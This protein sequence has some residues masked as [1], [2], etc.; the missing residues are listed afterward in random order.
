MESK[1]EK[2]LQKTYQLF[3]DSFMDMDFLLEKI[4]SFIDPNIMGYGTTVDEFITNIKDYLRLIHRQREQSKDFEMTWDRKPIFRRLSPAEDAALIIEEFTVKMKLEG[5]THSI[6]LRVSAL[7]HYHDNG[8]K[9]VHWHGSQPVQSENDT[10]HLDEWRQKNE[11]LQKLV[12]QQTADLSVKN[13]ELEIE[14]AIERVR[15]KSMAMQ[16]SEDLAELS[17]VLV[18]QVQGLGVETWFCAFNIYDDQSEGSLEW[19]CNG[20]NTF[21]KYGTPREGIFLKYYEAGQRGES[22]LVNEINENECAAHYEYLC[23]LPGVGDQL[24]KMKAEGIPFPTAQ[25]DHVAFFKFG[26]LLFIT[27]DPAPEAHSIFRRFAQVFEQTYTR[28]LDLQKAEA[29]AREAQIEAALERVR[30]ASMAM[31]KS[32]ELQNVLKVVFNQFIN[33]RLGIDIAIIALRPTDSKDW[34]GWTQSESTG[35]S[36]IHWP[37]VDLPVFNML[38]NAWN[39]NTPFT[40]SHTLEEKNI[41]WKEFFKLGILPKNREKILM[42]AS[43]LEVTGKYLNH[44]GIHVLRYSQEKFKPQETEIVAR[45]AHVFEQVYTRFLDLQKA[46]AQAR[47]AE[48]E[49]AL[50]RVRA[51]TLAMHK[52]QD[53][54]QVVNT[55]YKQFMVLNVRMDSANFIIPSEDSRDTKVWIGTSN[56]VYT[57]QLHLPYIDLTPSKDFMAA[58]EKGLD[59][60]AMKCT[61]EEKN[62]WFEQAYLHSDFKH[63]PLERKKIVQEAKLWT[64]YWSLENHCAIQLNSFSLESFNQYETEV[65]RRFTKVFEQAYTRFLDLQKAEKQAREAQIE[66]ALERVRAQ[67]M[68]MHNT[69]DLGKTIEVYF[70]QL[71]ALTDTPIVRCGAGLLSKENTMA[72]MSTA[73]RTP[74]GDTFNVKGTINMQ[75][76]PL[77]EST[78]HH[79]LKQEEHAYV[80]RGEEIEEYYRYIGDQVAHPKNTEGGLYFY[81]PMFEEGSFYVI[82][83]QEMPEIELTVFRRFSSVL[84]LTYRRFNDLKKVEAQ[85]REAEIEASL[86]RVRAATMAMHRSEDLLNILKVV[87][88]QIKELGFKIIGCNFQ[89]FIDNSRDVYMWA[90]TN[91]YTYPQK[92]KVPNIDFGPTKDMWTAW[93]KGK[94]FVQLQYDADAMRHWWMTAFEVSDFRDTPPARKKAILSSPGWTSAIARGKTCAIQI[95]RYDLNSFTTQEHSILIRFN[96]VFEQAYSRFLDLQKAE[97]QAREAEIELSLERIRAAATAMTTSNDLQDIVVAMRKEFVH[98]GHE[99][100]YFWHMRWL[101]DRYDKAMTTGEGDRIGMVMRLP[102][103][104]HGDIPL[105][106]DWEKSD[107]PVLV[108]PMDADTAVNYVDKMVNLG[109]FQQLDPN[110][111]TEETIQELGGVTFI[112]AR[113]THGEIGY[114][115]NGKVI[116]PSKEAI[117]T[118]ARFASAFDLAYRRFEDLL[119]SEA[120]ER[121]AIKQASI[122]RVRAEIA[123][124][125]SP[126]DLERITPLVWKELTVLGVP[127]FRCGVFIIKEEEEMVHAYLSTPTGKSLAALHIPFSETELGL[128]QPSIDHWRNQTVYRE[129]WDQDQ[130]IQN[131][132]LF[133]KQGLIENAKQYQAGGKP[134]EKLVLHLVPFKQGMLYVGNSDPLVQEH[135][136]LIQY[137]ASAFAVAYARYEDF[138]QLEDAKRNIEH[139]LTDLKAAQNQLVHSEKMASLGELTAG[140]AH[141]IQNPLNFVNNFSDLNKELIEELQEAIAQNDT[142]EVNAILADLSDNETKITHHGKR[143]EQIVKSML[144]HSR[145]SSGEKVPTDINGLADEYLRLAYHGLRAKDKS[146]NAD[147]KMDFDPSLPM[148]KVV[149]QDIGRVLLNLINNAFQ[150]VQAVEKPKVVVSTQLLNHQIEIRVSDN[151]PGIPDDIKDKIF[152]PFFTT[153]PTGEGTGLGLSMSYDIVTKGHGGTLELKTELG[154][155]TTFIVQ[156]PL[157]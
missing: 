88:T 25:I 44:S 89:I 109:D 48:I 20:I 100:H 128:I 101:T 10:W 108:F 136:E 97:A 74:E 121:E 107:A 120:R 81:F 135:V 134:P 126:K 53:L 132:K 122:D 40:F 27:Y 75:G 7:F 68:A 78:Y 117:D 90:I 8:W 26:Y 86:E 51:A 41:F 102:R 39:V 15:S 87:H 84:S 115:L 143:A 61:M 145:S 112:M 60:L 111:P 152:Q 92:L 23:S 24:L 57:H 124:M 55:V 138:V 157:S 12:D 130:F 141:E 6:P 131:M 37:Y 5:D 36:S 43:G 98:L 80:L 14:A 22:L 71:D 142:E 73:S 56:E 17:K 65:L 31:H 42:E 33:L 28:F 153:K 32:S 118:L 19:G 58:R 151:G 3:V 34:I 129:E 67:A 46:E 63:I 137:L 50:E 148:I 4:E 21:P 18:Q 72:I 38:L 45:F 47:E 106:A 105:V 113:T 94:T 125:R 2:A 150:A 99:A 29:Q 49:A 69:E 146:F 62:Q 154:K 76:H 140:I 93:D 35:Y 144:Q 85:A 54:Q 95:H 82:S 13:R 147:F 155:G 11:A 70:E 104:I 103:H 79:W 66:A 149:A 9:A 119:Q 64:C 16:K 91:A 83:N 114:S 116:D 77:L 133:M 123:S 110:A 127:F 30:A 59:F 96:K 52:S 1:K 139:T 156:L